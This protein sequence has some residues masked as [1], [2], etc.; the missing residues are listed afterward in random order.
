MRC[1]REAK[2]CYFSSTRRK[3]KTPGT[4]GAGLSDD[5]SV[6]EIKSGRKRARASTGPED[7]TFDGQGD[8]DE[9][10]TPGGKTLRA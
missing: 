2:E 3:K 10:R 8:Y 9:P 1:R 5:D 4:E 7:D 6:Y